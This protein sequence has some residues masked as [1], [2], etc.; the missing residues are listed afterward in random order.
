MIRV[1]A[2]ILAGG[3]GER[4]GGTVK[5]NIEIGGVRLL[6]RVSRA[7]GGLPRPVLV[8]HGAIGAERLNPL[9]GQ[10]PVADLTATYGGPLAGLAGAVAWLQ[11]EAPPDILVSVAVDT[12]FL[13]ADVVPRLIETLG[14]GNAAVATYDG[15]AYPTNAIWRLASLVDLPARIVS[16]T[17]PRSLKRL[18]ASLDAVPCAWPH[19]D[20]GDPFANVNTPEDLAA[21]EQRATSA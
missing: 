11:R 2:V 7:L 10:V 20:R 9:E 18:A 8:A 1:A 3:R 5:A 21:L 17:A 12:P 15:Q 13:P 6:E 16:G 4:L 19:D 14:T